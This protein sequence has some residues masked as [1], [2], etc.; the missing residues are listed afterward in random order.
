MK[1]RIRSFIVGLSE[2]SLTAYG[3]GRIA[4]SN[5]LLLTK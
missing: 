1:L 4:E 3:G 5:R 2:Y